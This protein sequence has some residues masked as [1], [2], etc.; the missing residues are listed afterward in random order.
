MEGSPIFGTVMRKK[1]GSY[2]GM[3]KTKEKLAKEVERSWVVYGRTQKMETWYSKIR[4]VSWF[5]LWKM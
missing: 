3:C 2:E 5:A 1:M 4:S